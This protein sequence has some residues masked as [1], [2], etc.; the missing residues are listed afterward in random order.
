MGQPKHLL[1]KEGHSWLELINSR[2]SK[3]CD[4]VVIVGE[5]QL[6]EGDWRRLSDAPGCNGPL[7]GI[8]AAMRQ[9]PDASFIICACDMPEVSSA[10]LEW[11]LA[12]RQP[13]D[14]A[15]VPKINNYSQPLFAFYDPR[16]KPVFEDLASQGIMKPREVCS[17]KHVRII[18]PPPHLSM[19]WRNINYPGELKE[20][21]NR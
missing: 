15:L 2:L 17:N 13:A 4:E 12:Q 9:Y 14:W 1:E 6:P 10:A 8:L 3:I 7:A 5:G 20:W 21:R 11:L 19:A 16:I 18:K